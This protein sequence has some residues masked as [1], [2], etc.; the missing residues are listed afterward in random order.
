MKEDFAPKKFDESNPDI[1]KPENEERRSFL[2]ALIGIGTAG[3]GAIL[4][5]PLV[6]YTMHPLLEDTTETS[7]A[8]IGPID[9]FTSLTVPLKKLVT[10]EQRDGWRKTIS[11]K[12]LYVTKSPKGEVIVLSAVCPHLG[13]TVP[14]NEKENKFVCPC[15]LGVFEMTGTRVQGPPPRDMDILQS[16]VEDGKLKVRYQFF[17]QL[18]SNKEV[19]A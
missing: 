11:E 18:S 5:V 19:M 13:C 6:R 15:H 4:F 3:V 10:I 9:E 17:R 16:K 7:W 8:E 1:V 12:P 2:G 14:W